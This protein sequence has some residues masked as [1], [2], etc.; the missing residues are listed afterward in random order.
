M[1]YN[2]ELAADLG[3][4]RTDDDA[5]AVDGRRETSIDGVYAVGD[6]THG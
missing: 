5:I 3:C 6:V 2:A 1:S 4:E